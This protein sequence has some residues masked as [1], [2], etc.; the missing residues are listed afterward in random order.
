MKAT[1]SKEQPAPQPRRQYDETFKRHAVDLT[2][3]GQR[4]VTEIARELG[5]ARSMV[6]AWRR[7]YAPRPAGSGE[8]PRTLEE[9]EAENARLRAEIVRLQERELVLK[10]SLGI[11]SETPER[12]LP[13]S[14]R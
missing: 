8:R 7:K 2:V 11:L 6:Y 9:A 13:G 10:K 5:V 4:R 1:E 12:G 14:K 3:Q